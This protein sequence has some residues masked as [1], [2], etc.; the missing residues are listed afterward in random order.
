MIRLKG[1]NDISFSIVRYGNVAGSR[2]SVIPFFDGI[3]KNG[4]T[5]LPV[6]DF[7]GNLVTSFQDT[8]YACNGTRTR[9]ARFSYTIF[10]L[11]HREG[12]ER[13]DYIQII[14]RSPSFANFQ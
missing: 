12:L 13:A 7:G 10:H 9:R 1:K 6:T 14:N 8:T 5:E 2:G 4:G 11:K 3:L